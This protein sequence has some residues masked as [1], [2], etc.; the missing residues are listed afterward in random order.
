MPL[1]SFEAD[2]GSRSVAGSHPEQ[3]FP[4][5]CPGSHPEMEA[6]MADGGSR[7]VA[8]FPP[9]GGE[10]RQRR[11]SGSRWWRRFPPIRTKGTKKENK[12][13]VDGF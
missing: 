4:H 8:Q 1:D 9:G 11:C 7:S 6:P 5:L 3:W 2:D 10:S 12:E 13:F